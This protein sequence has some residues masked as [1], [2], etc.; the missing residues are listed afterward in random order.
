MTLEITATANSWVRIQ[1]DS[2]PAR[3]LLM[4]D[5]ES[6]VITADEKFF[7]QTGNAGALQI[8]LNG[9]EWRPIGKMNEAV[10]ISIP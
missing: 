8:R 10:A 7:I 2:G 3:E 4:T 1:P 6:E 5:G 9:K